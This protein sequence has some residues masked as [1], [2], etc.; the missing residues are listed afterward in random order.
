MKSVLLLLLLL[1][2]G[3]AFAVIDYDLKISLHPAEQQLVATAQIDFN[4]QI[5]TP[6]KL[7]LSSRCEILAVRQ[8]DKP[9]P[10]SFSSGILQLEANGTEQLSIS[11]QAVFNDQA[12]NSPAH[13]E[14]PSYGVSASI[15]EAGTYLSSGVNWYP[16]VQAKLINYRISISTPLGTEA[17]TSGRRLLHHTENG[18]NSSVWLVDYPVRGLTLSA[19]TYQGFDDLVGPVPIYAYFTADTAPLATTY[20][21]EARSYL[22]LYTELFGPY[23]F[24]K[25]AIVENFFPTGYG[26]ASWTLL[27]SSVIKL[28]F[29]VKTS[30]GHEIA[31]SW[32]GTSVQVDYDQGNWAEGLTTY[33]ADYLY[34]ERS[35]AA[36]ARAYR[37][38]VLRNY[39]SLV[40]AENVFPVAH[41]SS[42]HDKASQSI[43]YSKTALLFHMLRQRIG[44]QAFW[45]GLRKIATERRHTQV[46]W[47]DFE[48][49]FSTLSG[50][51]LQSFFTQWLTNTEGPQLALQDVE[52][53]ETEKGWRVSGKLTQ[54]PVYRL[55]V[56]LQLTT[57]TE[58]LRKTLKLDATTQAFSFETSSRPLEL[59]AD[60]DV[61]LFRILTAGEIPATVN[62]IRGS[63]KLL[64]LRADNYS[65]DAETI[66]TLLDAMRKAGLPI[67]RLSEVS[68]AELASHD[69]LIFGLPDQLRPAQLKPATGGQFTLEQQSV[70]LSDHSAFVV[71]TNPLN[72]TKSAAWFVS[73]DQQA[74]VVARKIPHYGKY[75]TLLFIGVKNSVK[76][77]RT[78]EESPLKIKF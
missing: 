24:H 67:R 43:G 30:L 15:S 75:S 66:K 20:L 22:Q 46:G 71:E 68:Q 21:Q 77:T 64:V 78:P 56:E 36:E 17:I 19:G 54:Q 11:Y 32:W 12:S 57:Q 25:F 55:A 48:Q 35:S 40:T 14:D 23:P 4:D 74:A 76:E 2:P 70:N 10:Y 49:V 18:R 16:H 52:L 27:G 6:L 45:A 26:F 42:R 13:N 73:K 37:L 62:S 50:Q 7:P 44:D 41:F 53:I 3:S 60:P 38:K 31:H 58:K 69:L 51:D 39:A 59:Q 63:N 1:F 29:I 28:P 34:K 65:P 72:T 9:V 61:D 5:D 8:G 33:V 47:D